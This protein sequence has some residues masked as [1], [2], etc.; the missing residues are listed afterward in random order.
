MEEVV[1]EMQLMSF[2]MRM[3]RSLLP[4]VHQGRKTITTSP[5][6]FHEGFLEGFDVLTLRMT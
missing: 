2:P 3:R 1:G 4:L 5:S 6:T